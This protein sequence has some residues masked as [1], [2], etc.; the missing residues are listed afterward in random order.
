MVTR[1]AGKRQFLSF[2]DEKDLNSWQVAVYAGDRSRER[3]FI[4]EY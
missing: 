2:R 3:K 4:L 1:S